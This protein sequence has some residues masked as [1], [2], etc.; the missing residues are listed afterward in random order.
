MSASHVPMHDVDC[1]RCANYRARNAA[2]A[3]RMRFRASKKGQEEALKSELGRMR[4]AHA[5]QTAPP[6]DPRFHRHEPGRRDRLA[7]QRRKA[8]QR[9]AE[10]AVAVHLATIPDRLV[11][12]P[13]AP[14]CDRVGHRWT[15]WGRAD[16]D[17]IRERRCRRQK[18]PARQQ[19]RPKKSARKAA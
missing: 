13:K 2:Y 1:D 14:Y 11:L 5:Y 6:S 12:I 7:A 9:R 10:H 4:R 19:L 15:D 17:G 8:N 3:K 18:C 16:A